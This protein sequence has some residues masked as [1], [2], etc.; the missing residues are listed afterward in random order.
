MTCLRLRAAAK[1]NLCLK[2]LGR[3]PDGFHEIETVVQSVALHDGLELTIGGDG[4]R[5]EVDDARLPADSRNLVWSA[6]RA[7]LRECPPGRGLAMRLQKRIPVAAG[8][9]GGSS[10]AAA[11]LRGVDVLYALGLPAETLERHAAAL[12]SDVPYFLVGG[13]ALLTGRGTEVHPLPD[14]PRADLVIASSKETLPTPLVYAQLQEPLTLARRRASIRDSGR[15]P[16]DLESL[17]RL[18][19]DLEPHAVRL[20]PEIA[21]MREAL[22]AAG[23]RVA[24]MSG[25]GSAVFGVF[26]GAAAAR[27]AARSLGRRGFRAQACATVDRAT[28][29][30]EWMEH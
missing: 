17:V 25:S 19:N 8:L 29:Q 20:C 24:A 4:I 6:A 7:L 15:I 28:Y 26:G 5:L 1:V 16:A 10:D 30:R 22:L 21:P 13:T 12:G 9:G 3:R 2:V 27:E 18:G 14:L 11:A 23:A